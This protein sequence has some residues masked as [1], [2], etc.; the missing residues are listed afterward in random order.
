LQSYVPPSNSVIPPPFNQSVS[1]VLSGL[2]EIGIGTKAT[3]LPKLLESDQ[4]EP[5][6]K[7][8][9]GVRA[10]FQGALDPLT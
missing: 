9:S 10:Y 2:A 4:Y 6:I 7:I 8:M 1:K 3:D 5:A